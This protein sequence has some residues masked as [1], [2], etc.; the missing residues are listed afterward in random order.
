[1]PRDQTINHTEINVID[2]DVDVGTYATIWVQL[3]LVVHIQWFVT[4]V[5][6]LGTCKI[7]FLILGWRKAF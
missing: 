6:K 7:V 5:H 2:A 3:T 1:M 4:I